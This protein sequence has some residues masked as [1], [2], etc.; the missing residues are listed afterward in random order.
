MSL[1][2]RVCATSVMPGAVAALMRRP[3][4]DDATIRVPVAAAGSMASSRCSAVVITVARPRPDEVAWR[5]APWAPCCPSGNWPSSR[6]FSARSMDIWRTTRACG[7]PK[8]IETASTPVTRI[9][10]SA[11]SEPAMRAAAESLSITASTPRYRPDA[12]VM[13]AT[14]PPPPGQHDPPVR[15]ECRDGRILEKPAGARRRHDPAVPATGVLPH[16]PATL[17]GE[18]A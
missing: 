10:A 13:T 3:I 5:P 18:R 17:G 6:C 4:T 15:E 12:S 16:D 1:T 7:V 8:S 9:R 11:L 2:T 14:P